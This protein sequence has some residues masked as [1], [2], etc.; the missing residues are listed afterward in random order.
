M[1]EESEKKRMRRMDRRSS[2]SPDTLETGP[3]PA[4][5]HP[6]KRMQRRVP[7]KPSEPQGLNE[8]TNEEEELTDSMRLFFMTCVFLILMGILTWRAGAEQGALPGAVPVLPDSFWEMLCWGTALLGSAHLSARLILRR[9]FLF[10]S[11]VLFAAE[12]FLLRGS[13]TV[14]FLIFGAWLIVRAVIAIRRVV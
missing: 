10:P 5:G 13:G 2:R 12:W 1:T 11:A 14:L 8:E 6:G 3:E 7:K 4:S 9:H